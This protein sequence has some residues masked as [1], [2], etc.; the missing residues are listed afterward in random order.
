MRFLLLYID[1]FRRPPHGHC[2]IAGPDARAGYVAAAAAAVGV[3]L[4]FRTVN[5]SP[6]PE[7]SPLTNSQVRV[8]ASLKV[9]L[10]NP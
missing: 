1:Q 3:A 6:M 10:L 4:S 2:Q 9:N 8:L 7:P 5:E